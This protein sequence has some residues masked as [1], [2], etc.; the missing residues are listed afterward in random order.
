[1][2]ATIAIPTFRRP[3]GLRRALAS[4]LTQ[5]LSPSDQ[6]EILVI[7]NCP[8]GTAYEIVSGFQESSSIKIRYVHEKR[9]GVSYARN[10]AVSEVSGGYIAFLDDDEEA[11]SIWL[12]HMLECAKA[13]ADI[14]SGAIEAKF[15]ETPTEFGEFMTRFYSGHF[16][17]PA[18]ADLTSKWAYLGTGNSLF[19]TDRCFGNADPFDTK[20]GRIGGEDVALLQELVEDGCKVSWA[21]NAV[22][23]EWIPKERMTFKYLAR[24]RFAQGL[25]RITLTIYG[26]KR[27][28]QFAMI[29]CVGILQVAT[30]GIRAAFWYL[31]NQE[32]S[33]LNGIMFFGGLGKVCFF[34]NKRMR[35]Y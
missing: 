35:L 3:E 8:E 9:Q 5:E 12:G 18:G 32:R 14:V 4:S 26:R 19:S 6:Y 31:I 30:Y 1:M 21:P 15:E 20:F 29:Y 27:V 22:V 25:I 17:L 28:M 2:E 13:G 23:Y 34:L 33:R 10:R 16:E 11:T 24:R 7:D